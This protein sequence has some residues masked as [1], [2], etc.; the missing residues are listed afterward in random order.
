M[1][2]YKDRSF[3]ASPNCE[4]KCGRKITDFERAQANELNVPIAWGY[5]CDIPEEAYN[6]IKENEAPE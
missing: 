3:C 1:F 5:F 4:N 2:S 6:S